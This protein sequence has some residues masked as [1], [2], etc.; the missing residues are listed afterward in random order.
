ME[1]ASVSSWSGNW[2]WSLPIIMLMVAIHSLG[3]RRVD[4]RVSR[5]SSGHASD[6]LRSFTLEMIIPGTVLI[7]SILHGHES[8]SCGG[9][10]EIGHPSLMDMPWR[11]FNDEMM[12]VHF[13]RTK[14]SSPPLQK[15]LSKETDA[16]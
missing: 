3:L 7:A 12:Q 5:V 6:R 2:A 11:S 8:P 10:D 9:P 16:G 1:L 4:R 14:A 15:K 13:Q